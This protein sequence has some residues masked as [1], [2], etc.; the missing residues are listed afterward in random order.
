MRTAIILF[1]GALLTSGTFAWS[2]DPFA[3]ERYRMKTGRYTP[4][5]EARQRAV[6]DAQAISIV[7]PAEQAVCYPMQMSMAGSTAPVANGFGTEERFRLKY[8]RSLAS[9]NAATSQ[10]LIVASV[11]HDRCAA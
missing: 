7:K 10:R 2:S 1:A 6:Q 9:L 8:D 11:A 5:E 4:A 3:E